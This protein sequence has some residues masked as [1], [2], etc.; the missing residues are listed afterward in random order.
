ML[1]FFQLRQRVLEALGLIGFGW[2]RGHFGWS[3]GEPEK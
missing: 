2:L 3:L 1:D